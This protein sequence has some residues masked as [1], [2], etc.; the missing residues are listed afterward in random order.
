MGTLNKV[1]EGKA[2][3][4]APKGEKI[5]KKL[6]VF[7][8]PAMKL[9]RDISVCL[10]DCA[11]SRGM[12]IALPL[13]GTGVRGIRFL[14]ELDKSMI[15]SISMND[16]DE[17]AANVIN[18]NLKLNNIKKSGKVSVA[19]KDANLF[20]LE[21]SG[22]DYIDIDPFGSP[23][24]FL[25]SAV[26]RLARK[27]ILAVTATDTSALAGSFPSACARKYWA[28][29]LRNEIRHEAGLR[30]LIRKVQLI[31]AQFDKAL[32]PIYSYSEQHYMRAFF[33]CEKGK[34]RADKILESHG[35][36]QEAGPMWLGQLWDKKL[37]SDISKK[38]SEKML[39]TISAEAKVGSAGFHDMHKLCKRNRIR[40]I[41]KTSEIIRQLKK[42]KFSAAQTHFSPNGIRSSADEKEIL[43]IIKSI[44]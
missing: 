39:K 37:A 13:A 42:R 8:N 15:K 17:K 16:Y 43:K 25:D 7:Y 33:R 28:S 19:K 18:R 41:P 1:A 10:L 2:M 4:F 14:L 32:T 24:Y 30:I 44:R 3:V 5:S 11:G 23:N 20:L 34:R 40:Q 26:K 29:P 36:L 38:S 22:F 12:Q 31:G 6:P 21:S 35:T 9:N 27:G